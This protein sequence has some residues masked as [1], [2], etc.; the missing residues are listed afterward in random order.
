MDK[1][2]PEKLDLDSSDPEAGRKLIHWLR[3]AGSFI[4][5]INSTEKPLNK[6]EVLVQLVS[7]KVYEIFEESTTFDEA[8]Q[9]LKEHFI[10]KQNVLF[11]RHSLIT[12][13]QKEGEGVKDFVSSLNSLAKHCNFEA[14]DMLQ[15]KSQYI[16]DAFVQGLRSPATR[17]KILESTKNRSSGNNNIN[18]YIRRSTRRC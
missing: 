12:R 9:T 4:E 7:H 17:R 3:C 8:V 5:S 18:H 16:R 11:A 10:K 6:L 1:L 15:N 13:K 14:V 2:R